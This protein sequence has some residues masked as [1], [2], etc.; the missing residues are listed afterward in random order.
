[1]TELRNSLQSR[2]NLATLHSA[3][4]GIRTRMCFHERF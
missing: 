2:V 1:M 4:G 3:G